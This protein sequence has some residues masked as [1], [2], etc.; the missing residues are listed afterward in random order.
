MGMRP[1]PTKAATANRI[2][3]ALPATGS[4]KRIEKRRHN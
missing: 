4:G 2:V 3:A 1:R